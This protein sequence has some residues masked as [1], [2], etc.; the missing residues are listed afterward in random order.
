MRKKSQFEHFT[1]FFL[2]P[3]PPHSPQIPALLF[4]SVAPV[5]ET[6]HTHTKT[7]PNSS[8]NMDVDSMC[9]RFFSHP[10]QINVVI[11]IN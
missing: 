11:I 10:D 8:L 7:L 6:T 2:P 9:E 4:L 5:R 1:Q 3:T